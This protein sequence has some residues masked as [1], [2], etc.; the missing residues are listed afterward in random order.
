MPLTLPHELFGLKSGEMR[1]FLSGVKDGLTLEAVPYFEIEDLDLRARHNP[2]VHHVPRR[3]ALP[4]PSPLESG[5]GWQQAAK[6]WIYLAGCSAANGGR[7]GGTSSSL[8]K[9]TGGKA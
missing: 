3:R 7:L 1:V 2:Y 5:D 4:P 8:T 9:P 6:Q